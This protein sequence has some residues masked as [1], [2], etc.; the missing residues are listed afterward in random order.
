MKLIDNMKKNK[1]LLICSFVWGIPVAASFVMGLRLVMQRMVFEGDGTLAFHVKNLLLLLVQILCFSVPAA[2]CAGYVLSRGTGRPE[3]QEKQAGGKKTQ[4]ETRAEWKERPLW[5]MWLFYLAFIF[6]CW[7][8]VFLAYYPSVF[9][10]DAEGQLYQV[11]AGDYSTHHPLLHTLFL[12][13]FFRL[14]GRMGSYSA[15]MAVHSVVQMLLMAGAFAG[16]LTYLYE[17]R[18]ARWTRIVLLLFYGLFPT[19][20]VLAI[21]TTKDVLFSALV[22]LY[23]ICFYRLT[24]DRNMQVTRKERAVCI[25]LGV[26]MLLLRNNAVYAFVVSVPV[27][28]FGMRR[29]KNDQISQQENILWDGR[30]AGKEYLHLSL[31]ILL[32]FAVSAALL[33]T[34]TH[35]QSGSPRE[36]LSVPLQQMARVWVNKENGELMDDQSLRQEMEKYM[37]PEWGF[38]VYDPHLADRV[39]N[40]AI[41]HDDPKGLIKTWIRLGME[42]PGIYIDAF[43]DN[44]VGL[45]FLTD[46]THA[47]VY[48]IGTETGFGYLSTD[49]RTMPAGCEIVEHSYLPGLRAIMEKIVSDNEYEDWPVIK[50]LFAPALYWWLLY[51]YVVVVLYKKRYREVLPAVFLVVYY[52]TLLLSPTV[53]IRYM[54]PLVVTVPVILS[55]VTSEKKE[56]NVKIDNKI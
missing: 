8:P 53:L 33:K 29:V 4:E 12:G 36:M 40:I 48:G 23:T 20:S 11:I 18:T 41:I 1:R 51:L 22:L 42:Y 44:S 31:G 7:L 34:L 28:F 10:Y 25:L 26:L 56:E 5:Q 2:G 38:S 37:P 16:A 6:A 43:L 50:F 27:L 19:N 32:L 35:A 3:E 13:A 46:D 55:C 47:R 52:L 15:G 39:K 14:G 54:Y 24:C 9:A 30:A 49:N 17:K 21:S 45:W